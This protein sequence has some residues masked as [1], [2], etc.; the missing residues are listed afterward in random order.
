VKI[1]CVIQARLT[2]TR[3]PRKVL[4]KVK[5]ESII[6]RV[7]RAARGSKADKVVVAWAHKFPHLD[8]TDVL[9]RYK[10]IAEREKADVVVRITSDCPLLTHQ[11]VNHAIDRYLELRPTVYCNR[12]EGYRDGFDVQVF[13]AGLLKCSG[14]TDKEHVIAQPMKLSVDTAEDLERVRAYVA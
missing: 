12:D 6:S 4:E 13:H 5:G 14:W 10:E 2:S 3:L 8:E 9:G 1:V 7:C 11:I